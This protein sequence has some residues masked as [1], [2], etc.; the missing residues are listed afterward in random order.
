MPGF[1]LGASHWLSYLT[2]SPVKQSFQFPRPGCQSNYIVFS[3][4]SSSLENLFPC[5][6]RGQATVHLLPCG[7]S[8]LIPT[9]HFPLKGKILSTVQ[10]SA[11]EK[12]V[13]IMYRSEFTSENSG[14]SGAGVH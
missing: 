7:A 3:A 6:S 8:T 12:D 5:L 1:G 11:E 9:K 4:I 14:M 2:W 13:I 10:C